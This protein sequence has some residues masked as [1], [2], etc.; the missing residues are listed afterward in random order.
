MC[1]VIIK[2]KEYVNEPT[3][4]N[5]L[6]VIPNHI[7]KKNKNLGSSKKGLIFANITPKSLKQASDKCNPILCNIW[8]EKLVRKM[9]I[10]KGF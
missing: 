3:E 6:K 8:S 9:D 1:T 7:E 5:I 2:I 4:Y 10:F